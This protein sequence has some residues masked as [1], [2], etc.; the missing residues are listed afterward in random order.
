MPKNCFVIMGYG[1]KDGFDLDLI[2]NKIIRPT[3]ISKRLVP[4][5]MYAFNEC[6]AFRADEIKGAGGIDYNY[7]TCLNKAD[8]VIADLTSMNENAIYELGARHALKEKTTILLCGNRAGISFNF[9]DLSFAKVIT[10]THNGTNITP[11]EITRVKKELEI[12]IESAIKN[13]DVTDS[14]I[15]R[16]LNNEN[17]SFSPSNNMTIYGTYMKVKKLLADEK[18]S[19]ALPIIEKL[20]N[21]DPNEQNLLALLLS[22]YKVAETN[23]SEKELLECIEIAKKFGIDYSSSEDLF[24]R[25][26][27]IYLRLFYLTKEKEHIYSSALSYLKGALI[28]RKNLYCPRNFC[29]TLLELINTSGISELEMQNAYSSAIFFANIFIDFKQINREELNFEENIYLKCNIFDLK[30]IINQG[31]DMKEYLRI[32][33]YIMY[34]KDISNKQKNTI[35]VG[36]NRLKTNIDIINQFIS[37]K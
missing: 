3:I 31:Y 5:P 16:V 30:A 2:Y 25:L 27:A 26:G 32:K 14:P 35:L 12:R 18:Y 4:Y 13:L 34:S 9:Y 8:I 6:N 7:I 20:F 22:K 17:L 11:S 23:E 33:E 36:M 29:S 10:Y 19:I 15:L 37:K 1:V 28:S 21:A 24:G